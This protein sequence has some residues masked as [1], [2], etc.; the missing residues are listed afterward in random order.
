M[1]ILYIADDGT[2]FT[3]ETECEIYE[4]KLKHVHLKDVHAYDKDDN[5]LKDLFKEDT[6]NKSEKIIVTTEE[7]VKELQELGDYTGYNSY[8]DINEIGEWNFDIHKGAFV[9]V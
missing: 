2:Q 7:A 4:W 9:K 8:E 6:Y 5:E 3:D 1:K